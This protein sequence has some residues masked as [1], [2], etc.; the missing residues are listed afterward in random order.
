MATYQSTSA[1][2][3]SLGSFEAS[4][5][6]GGTNTLIHRLA[7]SIRIIDDVEVGVELM[8][9]ARWAGIIQHFDV[10]RDNEVN[11]VRAMPLRLPTHA[12]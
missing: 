6:N 8:T 1:E 5:V 12:G 2:W 3:L 4:P 11:I 9:F 10:S 7:H